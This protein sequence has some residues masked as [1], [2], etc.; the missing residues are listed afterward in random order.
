MQREGEDS[1]VTT[2]MNPC[3]I[4]GTVLKGS[5]IKP[6]TRIIYTVISLLY[7]CWPA[8]FILVSR[9]YPLVKIIGILD[10]GCFVPWSNT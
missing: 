5:S 7:N 1:R 8:T 2:K 6:T 4:W 3:K 10:G 9:S